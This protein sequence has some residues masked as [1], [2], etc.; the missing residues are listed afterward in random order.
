MTRYLII[1]L[2]LAGV[3][4]APWA[5]KPAASAR[6][7]DYRPED[8]IVVISPHVETIRY[9]FQRGF[10]KWMKEKHNRSVMIDWRV[11]G[12]TTEI[13]RYLESE[14]RA[15]FSERWKKEGKAWT[16]QY[17][18]FFDKTDTSEA[19][20]AFLKSDTGVRHDIFFGGGPLDFIWGKDVGVLVA[21]D[22]TGNHG[23]AAIAEKHPDWFTDAGIPLELAGQSCRDKDFTWLGTCFSA[24]GICCNADV[25]KARGHEKLPTD[26]RDLMDP[27]YRN[28]IALADPGKSGT[29]VAMFEAMI[30]AEMQRAIKEAE[31]ALAAMPEADRAK[32]LETTKSRGF[33]EGLRVVQRISANGRYWS[34]GSMKIP[35][36]VA[37]GEAMAGICLDFYGRNFAERT[38]RADGTTRFSYHTPIATSTS[39][40]PIGLLRGAPNP[41]LA[42]LFIEFVISPEGQKLWAFKKGTPGGPEKM[43]I[44][45][46]PVRRDYYTPENLQH[47]ADPDM[48]PY[49]TAGLFI[50]RP[51]Y[52]QKQFNAIRVVARA[53]GVVTHEELKEAWNALIENNFPPRA[54]QLFDNMDSALY[55]NVRGSISDRLKGDKVIAAKQ[56]RELS[57]AFRQQYL[58]V[59][60]LARR[61]E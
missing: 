29:I 41:E 50:Y 49:E 61:G 35:L 20:A 11:P 25:I 30:Q 37:E 24:F 39:V 10:Q 18:K 34:D 2:A 43:A 22:A 40:D 54:T 56:E 15:A 5:L 23:P 14:Y 1:L 26:W 16:A 4:A 28:Q 55:E 42:S 44:R 38:L 21:K 48:K 19:R 13:R 51:E 59:V 33:A 58:Q 31:P 46:M 27:F 52:T 6:A 8:V 9:E 57:E 32:A 47:S 17:E 7:R 53:M 12:G 3:I 60:E 36:D 45:R